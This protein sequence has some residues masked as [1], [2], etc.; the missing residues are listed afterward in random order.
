L[1]KKIVKKKA[2][3]PIESQDDLEAEA[4]NEV[5]NGETVRYSNFEY[6][7]SLLADAFGKLVKMN[8]K[9]PTIR[10]LMKFT[11][12][13]VNTIRRHLKILEKTEMKEKWSSFR[14]LTEQ[15]ILA[16]ARNAMSMAKGSAQ[17]AKLFLELVEGWSPGMKLEIT[18]TF[19]HAGMSN[20]ELLAKYEENGKLINSKLLRFVR[21]GSNPGRTGSS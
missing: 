6:N 12:L 13:S 15:V 21:M 17:S 3:K 9:K 18:N 11:Q 16:Q 8:G 1:K 19:N 14:I 20:E 7:Q 4:E 2:R 5:E 10:E